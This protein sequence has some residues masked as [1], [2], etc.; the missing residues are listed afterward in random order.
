MK[1]RSILLILLVSEMSFGMA[2]RAPQID[3]IKAEDLKADLYFLGSDEMAGR[4]TDTLQNRLAA[5]FIK[6]RFEALGLEPV[7]G[8][9]FQS[10]SLMTFKLGTENRLAVRS[11]G[12]SLQK[13]LMADFVPLNFSAT[14]AAQGELVFVGFGIDLPGFSQSDY[15]GDVRGKIVLAMQHEPGENDPESRFDG[16]VSSEASRDIRKALWAQQNG[17]IG[18]IFVPDVHNHAEGADFERQASRAWPAQRRRIP[19]FGLASWVEKVQI[20]AVSIASELAEHLIGGTGQS[21]QE[22]GLQAENR[23][24]LTPISLPG[25]RVRLETEVERTKIGDRNVVGLLPGSDAELRDEVII[26]C[27]HYDHDGASETQ[28]FNGADDDGSGT[29]GLIALARAYTAAA[30][31]GQRPRRSILFAAWNSEERGLLGA[32][33]Y[34]ENPLFPLERTAAVFNMDMIGRNEEVPA[35]GGRRFRGLQPQTAASNNNAVNVM[36]YTF[37][38]ELK[39]MAEKTGNEMGLTLRFRYDNNPSNLLR[40]SDHWPFLQSGVPA[41]FFHTGL[42]PDYHTPNDR[43]ERINYPKMEKIVRVIYQLSWEAADRDGRVEFHRPVLATRGQ[44]EEQ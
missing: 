42:H 12:L 38:R 35:G 1:S 14:G 2:Q 24:G 21:L 37:N 26:L 16:L 40:R 41:L 13:Q 19:R 23:G 32:W 17:A 6:S 36:G 39:T 8:S 18:I 9:Y 34:T 5:Q 29:V 22:L 20:P 3:Q 10:Y 4:L 15:Q 11:E 30:R 44:M 31:A 27:A 43:P 7:N 25:Y 33:A 28:V